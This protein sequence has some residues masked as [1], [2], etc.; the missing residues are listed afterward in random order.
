MYKAGTMHKLI[1]KNAIEEEND[2]SSIAFFC[3]EEIDNLKK[4]FRMVL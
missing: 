2:S 1:Q 3:L 4:R